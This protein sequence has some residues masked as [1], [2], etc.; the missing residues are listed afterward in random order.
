MEQKKHGLGDGKTAWYEMWLPWEGTHVT[1]APDL[2]CRFVWT[3]EPEWS[4][5]A[6]PGS[7]MN[8]HRNQGVEARMI[9]LLELWLCACLSRSSQP[10]GHRAVFR[11]LK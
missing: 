5:D 8:N 9:L 11:A 7:P 2:S 1:L 10:G 6:S 4:A 3:Q